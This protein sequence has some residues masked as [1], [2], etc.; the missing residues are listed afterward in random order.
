MKKMFFAFIL[1]GIIFG[2]IAGVVAYNYNAKDI[3]YT[4][5]DSSW[6]VDNIDA[7]IKD[8][9]SN[10]I[11]LAAEK[12]N[13]Q[14]QLNSLDTKTSSVQFTSTT[15]SKNVELGFKPNYISCVAWVSNNYQ[16]IVYN[17]DFDIDNVYKYPVNGTAKRPLETFF[18]INDNGFTWNI[19]NW[20]GS[21]MY[22]V[23]S[24]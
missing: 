10:I 17:K 13:L 23:A 21:T 16:T 5:N 18:T 15:A 19:T 9:H 3:S 14:N 7:A 24:K 6:N 20:N 4:P 22:C 2:S 12:E 11:N 1:G 8:M